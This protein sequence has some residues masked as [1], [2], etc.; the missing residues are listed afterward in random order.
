M[1]ESGGDRGVN[2]NKDGATRKIDSEF[3]AP[4]H[5]TLPLSPTQPVSKIQTGGEAPL[6]RFDARRPR[7]WSKDS[8]RRAP[9]KDAE[10]GQAVSDDVGGET[11]RLGEREGNQAGTWKGSRRAWLGNFARRW[12][13]G[14]WEGEKENVAV[15]LRTLPSLSIESS[16]H[17]GT[18]S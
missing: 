17:Q 9:T 6:T 12:I 4:F 8:I 1:R 5:A 14:W 11:A 15:A 2:P 18:R 13:G 3:K 10:E 16:N 7:T